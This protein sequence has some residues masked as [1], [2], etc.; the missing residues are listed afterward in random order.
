MCG[1]AGFY[2]LKKQFNETELQAMTNA[3]QHRGP[4]AAGFFFNE[5]HTCGLG[6]R[7]L[8][9]IDLSSAANQPMH[10][11]SGRHVIVFNGEV[12]NF[13]E[14]ERHLGIVP[15]TLSDTEIILEAFEKEGPEFVS[16]LNGMFAIAIYDKH[17]DVLWLFRDRLGIKPIYYFSDENGFAFG[18][19]IKSL[20]QSAYIKKRVAVHK[21]SVYTF[22]YAGY[23]PEPYTIY[24][25]ILRLPSGSY[26]VVRKG[27]VETKNYWKPDEKITQNVKTDFQSAKD[28]LKGLLTSS[29]AYRMIS[30]VPFG[31]FLSGGIDSSTVTAIAQS[32][33]QQP[34]KTFSIGFKEAKFDESAYARK[35]SKHLGTH[36]HEFTVTENDALELIDR[37]MTAYDEPYA[38][39]SA[40]PTMLVSKLARKYVTM[41]L[42]GDGGDELFLG[43]GMYD[44]ARRLHN[45]L[46]KSLRKPVAFAL[47]KMDNRYK[48]ASGVFN[49][50]SRE[51]VKSHIFSQEQYFFSE[52]ELDD[53]MLPGYRQPLLF[54]EDFTH[55]GRKLSAQEE[56]ALF[57][58]KHYLKDDLLVKVDIASMQ[59]S[60]EARVPF[61][62]YRI[63]EF[64]LNLSEDLK[65][66]NGVTKYLLKE[67]LYDYVP[68]EYFER[69]KWG[70]SIPLVKWLRKDLHYLIEQFLNEET[71]SGCGVV[72]YKKVDTL[73]KR[74]DKGEDFLY[75][76]LWA[77][78]LLHKWMKGHAQ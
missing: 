44:W 56:Q 64:A 40:I 43:Y 57:D 59:F 19:E 38:D 34:V 12:Y 17:D 62:D 52:T 27:K 72:D 31:T 35:V 78:I 47:S 75:N 20:L 8:S 46:I 73:I 10:S 6:H 15:R 69:P 68:R 70:F 61:L 71:I 51:R 13:K 22:L 28:E 21:P 30:D 23:I 53:L 67:V 2:S 77:L 29:V 48:R 11:Q 32:I 33:S 76:R 41:T 9:I 54:N 42:S 58:I 63:V 7:R 5:N 49:Y 45:P 16:L 39:S 25:N 60:L 1:I 37:M 26:C 50:K 3:M 14:I 74:F 36:H 66:K 55:V 24:S 4:D 65:K 18:S